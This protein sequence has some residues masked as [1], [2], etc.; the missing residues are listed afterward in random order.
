MAANRVFSS[1]RNSSWISV[2]LVKYNPIKIGKA[3]IQINL[4]ETVS[5]IMQKRLVHGKMNKIN[6]M[7][8]EFSIWTLRLFKTWTISNKIQMI[9]CLYFYF[10]TVHVS[11]FPQYTHS[12][13]SFLLV[14]EW[15]FHYVPSD[16]LGSGAKY[17]MYLQLNKPRWFY[18]RSRRVAL[19]GF[20][21]NEQK[22]SW[23]SICVSMLIPWQ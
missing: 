4:D 12:K 18:V 10:S 16:N 2:R 20:G 19:S 9:I 17:N 6:Q 23:E 3:P 14:F 21:W 22:L 5:I 13:R 11:T 15:I 7:T 1:Q 8:Q